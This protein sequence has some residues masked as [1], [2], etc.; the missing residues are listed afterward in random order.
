M[1]NVYIWGDSIM[2]GLVFDEMRQRYTLIKDSALMLASKTLK[3]TG[4]S[5]ARI[6]MTSEQGRE[7]FDRKIEDC[8]DGNFALIFF[9]G[10]DCDHEW[11]EIAADPEGEH[12]AKVR[13]DRFLENMRYMVTTVA[14]KG[15]QPLMMTLPAID[16]KRYFRWFSKDIEQSDNIMR[17][18]GCVD[19]IRWDHDLYAKRVEETAAELD[20]PIIDARQKFLAHPDDDLLCVDGIHPNAKG[21]NLIYQAMVEFADRWFG[22][23][24]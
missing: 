8:R 4:K 24:K 23:K 10:N 11:P 15:L 1:E 12:P 2:K 16:A 21:Q 3:M 18:L 19:K 13:L 14:K 20:C 7:A 22:R 5:F 17:W 9:G 6:G